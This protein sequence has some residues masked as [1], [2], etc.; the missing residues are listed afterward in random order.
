MTETAGGLIHLTM[1]GQFGRTYVIEVSTNL[2]NWVP[3]TVVVNVNG[4][5]E[6]V[7]PDAK[8]SNRRFYRAILAP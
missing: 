1:P 7:D 6:V 2:Q 5:L 8:K 3:L 4:Q